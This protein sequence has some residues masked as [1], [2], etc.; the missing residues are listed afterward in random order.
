MDLRWYL[1]NILFKSIFRTLKILETIKE[2]NI[3]L[4][5]SHHSGYAY[6]GSL[7]VRI[8][9]KL[10]IKVIE[11]KA[12]NYILWKKKMISNGFHN[13]ICCGMTKRKFNI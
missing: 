2:K 12:S 7:S 8:G 1:I 3:K 11:S 9:V 6:N 13:L 4:I 10:G 5:V